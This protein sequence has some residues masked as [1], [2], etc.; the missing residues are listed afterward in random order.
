M[1][2]PVHIIG[3]F[4]HATG[5]GEQRALGLGRIIERHTAVRYWSTHT[6]DPK[7][8]QSAPI[9][10]IDAWRM[11][12]PKSGTFVFVGGYLHIGRWFHFARPHRKIVIFNTRQPEEL[13]RLCRVLSP[14]KGIEGCEIVYAD[15]E[16][17]AC[18]GVPGVIQRSPIDIAEFRPQPRRSSSTFTVGR[19]SRDY[20]YKF[21]E[22]SPRL[23]QR[24][25]DEGIAVRIMGGTCLTEELAGA[26]HITLFPTGAEPAVD[27]LNSIDCFLYRTRS[28]WYETYGRVVFEAMACGLPVVCGVRGGYARYIEH[29][30]NGYLFRDGDEALGIIR[31]LRDDASLRRRIGERARATAEKLYSAD[32]DYEIA[33]FYTR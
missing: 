12:F 3:K 1:Q 10:K 28:D 15:E 20:R 27:F 4:A 22:N 6:P 13:A 25:S 19:M 26:E 2:Y 16:L 33:D 7:L 9:T 32:F 17:Q 11:C 8:L 30:V 14:L 31:G 5:G 23:Y 24:L 29:G 18:I 21:H